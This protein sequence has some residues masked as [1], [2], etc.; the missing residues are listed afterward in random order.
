[1]YTEVTK[2]LVSPDTSIHDTVAKAD[3]N[4]M[5]I[6]LVVD[7]ERRLIGTVTDGDVRRAILAEVSLDQ[8]VSYLL[9][10][11][12]NSRRAT[13][14]TALAG[15]DRTILLRILREHNLLHLPLLD[16]DQRV[17]DLVTVNDLVAVDDHPLQAVIMAGGLG[18]RMRPL[19][20]DTPKPMLPVGDRPLLEI[21]VQQLRDAGINRVNVA[22]HHASEK[23]ADHFGDG[24]DFGVEITYANEDR[25]LGTAGALGLLEPPTDTTLVINGDI[26]TQLDF[27][28]MLDY[29]L[30]NSTELTVAVRR[31][32]FELP[33]GVVECDGPTVRS[34]TEKP[35]LNYFINAGIYLLEPSIYALIPCGES[36][37]MTD[38]MNRLLA[39]GRAISAFPVREYWRDIGEPSDYQ[40]AQEDMATGKV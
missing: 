5:G 30:E 38:L 3:E 33:Y 1:M 8:P 23:I 40:Q 15:S 20:D 34:V 4:R 27:K 26:L 36:Y 37:H 6:V 39:E 16:Q 12:A 29:H 32:E 21:I 28:A 17:I 14:V 35:R 10:N 19:T 18:T 13:P 31:Q 11:K 25:P 9:A 7:E 22:V 24:S 2:F